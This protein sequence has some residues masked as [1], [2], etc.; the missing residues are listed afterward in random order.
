MKDNPDV[1]A[2]LNSYPEDIRNALLRLRHMIVETAAGNKRI[3]TLEE[4]LKWGQPSYLTVRP[5]TGTTVRI[6]RDKSDAGEVALYVNC[7]TSLVSE[8][9]GM[10]PELTF[11]GDRSVHFKLNAP[12]PEEALRRMIS[13]ALG[14]H[15]A[16]G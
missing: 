11:G 16:Q 13:M 8:W 12:L 5:K 10:F 6:D 1:L 4:A 7:R 14:Y 15:R 9:R 2:L 3:G